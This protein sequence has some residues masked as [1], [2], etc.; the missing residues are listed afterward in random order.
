MYSHDLTI[1]G[2]GLAGLLCAHVSSMLGLR[3]VVLEKGKVADNAK[4]DSRLFAISYDN[5]QALQRWG[6]WP[7]SESGPILGIKILD[8]FTD[9]MLYLD[10]SAHG[11][12]PFGYMVP[13]STMYGTI[14]NINV[15]ENTSVTD[16]QMCD[17]GIKT[18]TSSGDIYNACLH[19]IAEGRKAEIPVDFSD[20]DY[21]QTMIT[22]IIEHELHNQ[23][24]IVERFMQNGPFAV[25]PRGDGYSSSIIWTETHDRAAELLSADHSYF[26]DE[27]KSK[28]DF[29]GNFSIAGDIGHY[30]IVLRFAHQYFSN[31]ILIFGD[32]V[33]GIHPVTGQGFNLTIRDMISLENLFAEAIDLGLDLSSILTQYEWQ[34]KRSNTSIIAATDAIN[35]LF[36]SQN[37]YLKILRQTGMRIINASDML[38]QMLLP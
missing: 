20:F 33:H 2:G 15:R 24:M 27:L 16:L 11:E 14:G 25:L 10:R 28:I 1:S 13:A 38:K 8:G 30:K 22:F 4:V 35:L 37:S 18:S 5:K 6:V 23:H 7:D 36:A 3:C 34:C 12:L 29:L 31:R 32:S 26:I 9:N 19:V 17:Y 21:H